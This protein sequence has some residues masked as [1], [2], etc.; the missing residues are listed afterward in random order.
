MNGSYSLRISPDAEREILDL[1][2]PDRVR[3]VRRI[4]GLAANP[5]P[6]GC[7]KLRNAEGYRV[8]QGR[9]RILY[10]VEDVVRVVVVY[11]VRDRK[12][13]YRD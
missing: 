1:P 10:T 5:R 2:R 3:V 9:Y 12:N 6:P 7:K 8:R 13:A 11:A 4:H